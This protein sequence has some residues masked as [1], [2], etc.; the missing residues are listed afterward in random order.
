MPVISGGRNTEM[1]QEKKFPLK[2]NLWGR[3][4]QT[5]ITWT[6]Y[7]LFRPRVEWEDKAVKK[8]L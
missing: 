1:D 6:V 5:L 2:Q 3:F 8:Q 4:F 7:F